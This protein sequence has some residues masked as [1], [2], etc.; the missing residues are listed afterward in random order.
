MHAVLCHCGSSFWV[1]ELLLQIP[2]PSSEMAL[3]KW[4]LSERVDSRAM[5]SAFQEWR[6][7][8]PDMAKELGLVNGLPTINDCPEVPFPDARVIEIP[9][10]RGMSCRRCR[11][12][13]TGYTFRW[14]SCLWLDNYT[15]WRRDR[16][17]LP[18][19]PEDYRTTRGFQDFSGEILSSRGHLVV[20]RIR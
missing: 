10:P 5:F 2:R 1:A 16:T 6:S 11:E 20:P 7:A 15:S 19:D 3:P 12:G 17:W 4:A 9:C 18:G 13:R 14:F 8:N